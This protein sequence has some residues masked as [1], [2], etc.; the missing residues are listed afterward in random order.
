MQQ[1]DGRLTMRWHDWTAP[2]KV[3]PQAA[4]ARLMALAWDGDNHYATEPCIERR[5][6]SD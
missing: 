6:L 3:L 5:G 2:E 4:R 1:I